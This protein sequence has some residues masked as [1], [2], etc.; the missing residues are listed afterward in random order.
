MKFTDF[1]SSLGVTLTDGQRAFCR[2]AFDGEEPAAL[3]GDDR[4]VAREI[5]GDVD[6]VPAIARRV[7]VLKKGARIGGSYLSALRALHLALTVDLS[8]LAP[9]EIAFATFVA[10][11]ESLAEQ[12]LRYAL[13]AAQST[14]ELAEMVTNAT[15]DEGFRLGRTALECHPAKRGGTGQR[16]R[17]LVCCVMSE[18]AFFYDASGYVVNDEEIYRAALPRI[19]PG[20]QLIIEST[21]WAEAG[22]LYDLFTANWSAPKTAL[23]A[24]C[25]TLRMRDDEIMQQTVAAEYER[26]PENASREFGAEFMSAGTELF[27]DTTALARCSEAV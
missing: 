20:G 17:A 23:A 10:P 11:D 1:V 9:G 14:A 3:D 2:V 13:G 19:L 4:E 21:P 8:R 5:F 22:L 12:T 6:T 7:I 26:D 18:A 15:T 16:S 27:F 25:P 24:D